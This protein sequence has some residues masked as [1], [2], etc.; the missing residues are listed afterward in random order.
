MRADSLIIVAAFAAIF[1]GT[2]RAYAAVYNDNFTASPATF[3]CL[4]S[5]GAETC[6][7]YT[8]YS[9]PRTLRIGDK[10]TENVTYTSPLVVPGSKTFNISFIGIY[11]AFSS[12]PQVPGP[13]QAMVTSL[14]SG[15]SGPPNP[16]LGG[17]LSP[18]YKGAYIASAGFGSGFGVPNSGFSITDQSS[19]FTITGSGPDP[20]L[21]VIYGYGFG[22]PEPAAWV[23]MLVG[24]GGLGASLRVRRRPVRI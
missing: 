7:G 15:Y 11:N 12:D 2:P 14:L 17:P 8:V 24:F 23:M 3:T 6:F 16:G 20:F 1:C 19:Q 13:Y 18:A 22:V 5:P 4:F 9:T 10:L 21:G